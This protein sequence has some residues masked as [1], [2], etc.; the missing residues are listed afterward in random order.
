MPRPSMCLRGHTFC[1]SSPRG[2]LSVPTSF[3][4]VKNLKNH[5]QDTSFPS[6]QPQRWSISHIT[7]KDASCLSSGCLVPLFWMLWMSEHALPDTFKYG[8]WCHGSLKVP[9]LTFWH[10]LGGS[11]GV[12]VVCRCYFWMSERAL[13]DALWNEWF[14]RS[15]GR[16][17]WL[18][19]GRV[20]SVKAAHDTFPACLSSS[21][22]SL[23][24]C[25]VPDGYKITS[26]NAISTECLMFGHF[27][28]LFLMVS[29][30]RGVS[31]DSGCFPWS[32]RLSELIPFTCCDFSTT[33]WPCSSFM[34][35]FFSSFISEFP[36]FYP[37][38]LTFLSCSNSSQ[39]ERMWVL[40]SYKSWMFGGHKGG[41]KALRFP[42]PPYSS[43][44][45]KQLKN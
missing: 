17:S 23:D 39:T 40:K 41:G 16:C 8:I 1:C 38:C 6:L 13:L 20:L 43:Q 27:K 3:L 24:C 19:F 45:S 29:L 31:A 10:S 42:L 14:L 5:T 12:S 37:H 33:V 44:V 34:L 11:S 18:C 21:C 36:D 26:V 30:S 9:V 22:R 2:A 4:T 28:L 25:L 32:S 35:Q 7:H 15:W